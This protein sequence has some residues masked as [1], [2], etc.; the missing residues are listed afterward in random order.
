MLK[1]SISDI[2]L[3]K[4][5][6]NSFINIEG[7]IRSCRHSKI[8]IS[9]IQIYDGSCFHSIQIIVKN[10]LKNYQ[11][12]ILILNVGCSISIHGVLIKSLGKE[13]FFEIF[14]HKVNVI[15]PIKNPEKYPISPKKH[16][17]EYL[18]IHAHL[19][20]RTNIITAVSRI[21]NVLFQ[22][23]N[24][25][26][27]KSGFF[28]IPTPIITCLNT[29]GSGDM[30]NVSTIDKKCFI[31]KLNKKKFSNKNFFGKKAF[32]TV[33]GQLTLEA[34]ACAYKKVYS[35]G[36]VFRAENSN[37]TRHLSE[38]WMLEIECAFY[39]LN[40]LI[41]FSE[42]I[43]KHI[44]SVILNSCAL[45]LEFLKN[46][47]DKNIFE[48]LKNFLLTKFQVI[49]YQEAL[50]IL[51]Y[52]KK[53]DFNINMEN[54]NISSEQERY[55]VD[56][57][58]HKPVII[59]NFPKKLKAFY[60]KINDDNDTVASMDILFPGIGEILGGSEREDR[61]KKLDKRIFECNLNKKDYW[62]YR[63]LRKYGSVPHA[64]FGLGIERLIS[65]ITGIRNVRDIIPFPRIVNNIDF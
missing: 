9:F 7:W 52:N 64:G 53:I 22:T 27:F 1:S 28:W 59:I 11:N 44:I 4:V 13:Q 21:R 16:T 19:R 58:F 30:F 41:F 50:N 54:V 56:E 62:W 45:E 49:T 25:F 37:T 31:G 18:R 57:Y 29:E 24:N 48:R 8:G 51:F 10:T 36:P 60:M 47:V 61:I 20:P 33:S 35:L 32:L 3:N 2:F 63:D 5:S 17:L 43:I 23:I 38:F 65:Y 26:L 34:Y 39:N 15:G 40:D 55:L 14:A 46:N 6:F 12:D 42:K